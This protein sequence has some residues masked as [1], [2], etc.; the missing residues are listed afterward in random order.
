MEETNTNNQQQAVDALYNYT[1]EL[2]VTQKKKPWEVIKML[3]ADGASTQVATTLV[4]TVKNQYNA[5]VT[6][7]ANKNMLAGGLWC[8]GGTLVTVLSFTAGG[9]RFV[10]AW[11]AIIF[12]AIQFF[13]GYGMREKLIY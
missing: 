1:L 10:L 9:S 13:K 5:E 6:K 12:G 4:N 7:S 2:L 8:V 11:G 3:E